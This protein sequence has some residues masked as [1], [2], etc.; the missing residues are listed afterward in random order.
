MEK[1]KIFSHLRRPLAILLAFIMVFSV[2]RLDG[3]PTAYAESTG[4]TNSA[5]TGKATNVYSREADPNTMDT[6]QDLLLNETNGSRYAGRIWTDKTVFA[7]GTDAANGGVTDNQIALDMATDGYEGSVGFSAD[8]AHVFSALASSQVVNEYPPQPLDVMFLLDVSGSMGATGLD[9][10]GNTTYADESTFENS[11]I[12]KTVNAINGAI[13]ILVEKNP[14]SRFGIA[15]YGSTA[16]VLV[17]LDHYTKGELKAEYDNWY[18]SSASNLQGVH[19][20]LTATVT[21]K[22]SGSET[23]YYADNAGQTS[24]Q[25]HGKTNISGNRTFFGTGGHTTGTGTSSADP[26][27]VGHITN[28]QAGLAAAMDQFIEHPELTWDTQITGETYVRL[29]ALIHLTDGQ[30]SDLSWI[31]S[32]ESREHDWEKTGSNWNNVDWR[33]DLAYNSPIN[34]QPSSSN[35]YYNASQLTGHGDAAPVIFQTLMTASYYKSAVE[36][37]Y[38]NNESGA[39]D[40]DG[41]P[42]S[43]SCYSIYASDTSGYNTL[44]T[45]PQVKATVDAILGPEEHF[46][47]ADP[48]SS[49][50][51]SS[52]LE[53]VSDA[54]SGQYIDTAYELFRKWKD[55]SETVTDTFTKDTT[56]NNKDLNDITITLNTGID[57]QDGGAYSAETW[58]GEIT[59]EVVAKNINYVPTDNFYQTGFAELDNLF[60][61]IIQLLLG[62]VFIPI[63][64]DNDAGV[65]DSITYQDPIGDLMEVKNR[66]ITATP[67]HTGEKLGL[68]ETTYDMAMLLFGEM[69]GMVRTGVYDY[70]WHS[71]YLEKNPKSTHSNFLTSGWYYGDAVSAVYGGAG[72]VPKVSEGSVPEGKN[73]TYDENDAGAAKAWTD[74]WV[75][76][77]DY[78][79]LT[80]FIP[81]TEEVSDPSQLSPQ[82]QN[83]V[84]TVYRFNCDNEDRNQLRRN[85]VYGAVPEDLKETWKQ[86]YI[87]NHNTYPA[88][89]TM[90]EDVPGVFRLSDIRVWVEEYGDYVD[91]GNLTPSQSY[92]SSLYVNIPVAAVPTQ[93]AE[94]SINPNGDMS[95]KTNLDT[96][97]QS[98][99][100]R[101]FYAVGLD[102]EILTEDGSSVNITAIPSEYLEEHRDE[103]SRIE[104]I[105]N[106]YSDTVYEDYATSAANVTRGD[107]TVSFSPSAD[108]RYYVFQKPLPL[109]AHAYRVQEDGSLALVDNAT[110]TWDDKTSGGNGKS[111]WESYNGVQQS[112]ASW[113]GGECLGTF[114]SKEKF[115]EKYPS[116][117]GQEGKIVF[118][119][120]DLMDHVTSDA[121]GNY[122]SGSLS[123]S[124]DDYFFMLVE[125]Y[126]PEKGTIGKDK[127]GNEAIGTQKCHVVQY[128]VARKGSEFGSGLEAENISNGDMLCWTDTSGKIDQEIRYNSRSDT[129]DNTR[130]EPTYEKL[131]GD[132]SKLQD[133]LKSCGVNT[134]NL[135]EEAQYW[136]ALREEPSIKAALKKAAE[137][138]HHAN[139]SELKKEE[140]EKSFHWAVVAKEGGLRVGD[141]YQNVRRKTENVTGTSSTYY[142]PTLSP[143][144]GI[145]NN[146]VI[147]NYLGNNGKLLVSDMLL[148]VTKTVKP[149][150]LGSVDPDESFS[151]QV[152]LQG[153][154]GKTANAVMVKKDPYTGLWRR[155][156]ASIDVLTN[157]QG[158]LLSSN[159]KGLAVVDENINPIEN[160]QSGEPSYYV[161]I[162]NS[163]AVKDNSVTVYSAPE[164][165]SE[166][167]GGYTEYVSGEQLEN[168]ENTDHIEYKD[169]D[170]TEYREGDIVFWTDIAISLIPVS[171]V[172]SNWDG[173]TMPKDTIQ[174]TD[175]KFPITTLKNDQDQGLRS[176]MFM[177]SIFSVRSTYLTTPVEFGLAGG[178]SALYDQTAFQNPRKTESFES[179]KYEGEELASNTAQFTLKDGEGLLFTGMDYLASFRV[180]EKLSDEQIKKHYVLDGVKLIQNTNYVDFSLADEKQPEVSNTTNW[181][182]TN[183]G[184]AHVDGYY[185]FTIGP[186]RRTIS[187]PELVEDVRPNNAAYFDK[188]GHYYSVYGDTSELEKAAHFTNTMQIPMPE[189]TETTPGDGELVG[190]G[191]SITYEIH[192]ENYFNNKN[193][194]EHIIV[195]DTLDPGVTY[196]EKNPAKAYKEPGGSEELT[197]D[198]NGNI[199]TAT[200]YDEEQVLDQNSAPPLSSL[201]SMGI[202]KIPARTV[203]WDLG[204]QEPGATGVVRLNVIVN[205]NAKVGY[206]YNDTADGFVGPQGDSDYEVFNQ[207][208]VKVGNNPFLLTEIVDNPVPDK[209]E[210]AIDRAGGSG[211]NTTS[212]TVTEGDNLKYNEDTKLWEGPL[213]N[214]GDKITYEVTWKNN[215]TDHSLI[216]VRDPLDPGVDFVSASYGEITLKLG[217]GKSN[218]ASGTVSLTGHDENGDPL[219]RTEIPVTIQYVAEG[220][221]G[222]PEIVWTIGDKNAA[223]GV[224][225]K[226]VPPGAGGTVGLVVE[227]TDRAT[228][229]GQVENTAFVRVGNDSVER[230]TKTVENPTPKRSK[231][232]T[233]PGNGKLVGVGSE[234]TYEINWK[235]YSD[236]VARIVVMDKLDPGVDFGNASVY[237]KG[238]GG[239]I[240]IEEKTEDGENI[241]I[242]YYKEAGAY[243]YVSADGETQEDIPV[244]AHTV[245]WDLGVRKPREEGYVGL[246]VKVNKNARF[247][248]NYNSDSTDFVEGAKDAAGNLGNDYEVFN[249][250]R[251]KVDNDEFLKTELVENPVSDKTEEKPGE[252]KTVGVGT[253]ITYKVHWE[254]PQNESAVVTITDPLDKGVDFVSA[255][256]DGV[257][258]SAVPDGGDV[259]ITGEGAVFAADDGTG[260][261]KVTIKYD[262]ENHTV[263]WTF[264]ATA[265]ANTEPDV[266]GVFAGD[267]SLEVCVNQEAY[268]KW[269]YGTGRGVDSPVVDDDA[270]DDE[271][272]NRAS[273]EVD[274]EP[275]VYTDVIH[276]PLETGSLTV[277]KVVTPVEV[278]GE[279]DNDAEFEFQVDLQAQNGDGLRGTLTYTIYASNGTQKGDPQ[280]YDAGTTVSFTLKNGEYAVF[281][282][283]PIVTK[284]VVSEKWKEDYY[285]KSTE[286]DGNDTPFTNNA[287]AESY[288]V[289]GTV[290]VTDSTGKVSEVKEV[291]VQYT[292]ER[293]HENEKTETVPGPDLQ[294]KVGDQITYQIEWT[295]DQQP[296]ATVK[297]TDY[298]DKGVDFVSASDNGQYDAA[299]HVV[300]WD[301][302]SREY[303]A[304][305][306][307]TLTVRVNKDAVKNW[308]YGSGDD[309]V[310]D[311]TSKD[312]EVR[313]RAKIEINNRSEYTD[314]VENPVPEK[315]ES[316]PGDGEIVG[317]GDEITYQIGWANT[318]DQP[319]T[320]VI[321]DPLDPG[322]DFVSASFGG[323]ISDITLNADTPGGHVDSGDGDSAAETPPT[324]E[325]SYDPGTH[326]VTWT[327]RNVEANDKGT[328][329]LTVRVNENAVK[330]WSYGTGDDPVVD[331]NKD[332]EV[333]NRAQVKV[334]DDSVY[335]EIV[336]NPI[337]E[338]TESDPGDG[339]LVGVGDEITYKVHWEN[340]HDQKATVTITDPLDRGVDFVSASL[341]NV[342]LTAAAD[343]GSVHVDGVSVGN[344][345]ENGFVEADGNGQKN[346]SITYDKNSHTVTW[347]FT[348]SAL[349]NTEPDGSGVFVG[350][351]ELKVK[352]NE[353]A[354]ETW[355]YHDSDNK[356][357]PEG[358][359][360]TGKDYEVVN[361]AL[362]Q[363]G[364]DAAYTNEVENPIPEK[365]ESTPGDGSLVGVGDEIA[366]K[367]H[368]ENLHEEKTVVTITD[369]LDQGVDFVS[370]SLGEVTLPAAA[371]GGST[372][373]EG[374]AAIASIEGDVTILYDK[375]SHA[376][377]WIFTADALANTKPDSDGTFAAD[378]ELKVKVNENAARTWTYG[379]TADK[380]QPG[381]NYGEGEDYEVVNRAL[382]Q[383]GDNAAYTDEV[384]NPVPGK[385]EEKPGDGEVVGVGDEITYKVHWENTNDEEADVTITDPLDDGVDFLSASLGSV[386]LTAGHA[387][388][389][390]TGA[391]GGSEPVIGDVTITYAGHVVTWT[392]RAEPH[393]SGDVTLEVKVNERAAKDWKYNE[394]TDSGQSGTGRDFKVLN[395][396]GVKVN[397][398]SVYTAVVENPVPEK[399]EVDPGD[400]FMVGLG[401]KITYKVHWENLHDQKAVVTI[402]D[403]LDKGVDFVSASFDGVTLT[404]AAD[405]GSTRIDSTGIG[406]GAEDALVEAD[407]NGQR[408]ISIAYDKESHTVT[409]TF[410]AR[411]LANTV[412]DGDAY[413]GDVELIV[414][415]NENAFAAWNYGSTADKTRPEGKDGFGKDY[416]VRNRALVQVGN[417]AAYT[418]EV[419][420]PVPEKRE[421]TPGSGKLVEV[422]D[423][424]N[425]EIHWTN[426]HDEAATVVVTDELDQGVDFVS[427]SYNGVVLSKD[428]N[429]ENKKTVGDFTIEYD[430]NE[431]TVT[432]TL[433][434]RAGHASGYVALVVSVNENAKPEG[435]VENQAGVKVGNDSEVK[436]RIIP[437]PTG[438]AKTE[439]KVNDEDVSGDLVPVEDGSQGPKVKV[440]D[441]VTYRITWVNS[442]EENGELVPATVTVRDPLDEGVDFESAI[443][444][445]KNGVKLE[446]GA[447]EP[448]ADKDGILRKEQGSAAIAYDK[449]THTVTWTLRD[450][451]PGETGTVELTVRVNQNAYYEWKYGEGD[452]S[453]S[454]DD[455]D[456][457]IVDRA[458]VQAGNGPEIYTE[459]IHNPLGTGRLRIKKVVAEEVVAPAE[460]NDETD[461][462]PEFTFQ[463]EL[464]DGS[465]QPLRG[466][467]TYTVY[468]SDGTVKKGPVTFDADKSVE[469][470][471]AQ[472]EYVLFD[473]LP[474]VTK[475]TVSEKWTDDYHLDSAT[476]DGKSAEVKY[477]A[478]GRRY[479]VSGSVEAEA[480]VAVEY[481]NKKLDLNQKTEIDPEEDR[482]VVVGDQITYQINWSNDQHAAANVKVTDY[483]DKGVDF[484]SADNNGQYDADAHTVT[485]DLGERP[486]GAHGTVTLTVAVNGNAVK[487]WSYGTGDVPVED[488]GSKDYEVRNR[489]KIEVGNHSEYTNV[490]EN[491]VPEKEE[492]TPGDGELVG[493]GD[494]IDYQIGWANTKN[495]KAKVVITDPLDQGVDFV[496]ASLGDTTLTAD[497]AGGSVSISDGDLT[498]GKI[499]TFTI[500]YDAENHVVTWTLLNTEAN[501]K[502]TVELTVRV[503]ENAVRT[504]TYDDEE[505]QGA[506]GD[507]KDYEIVNRAQ[508]SVDN[509]AVYTETVENPVPEKEEVT[510]GDGVLVG[511]GD[512]ISYKVHWENIH[513]R[514]AVVTITDPLDKGVDFVSASLGSVTLNAAADGGSVRID[515]VGIGS[516]TEDAFVE[517]DGNGQRKISI[518]YDKDSHTVTWTFTAR[519]LA[520]TEPDG[521]GIFPGDA[522]LT[523]KVNENAARTW[524]Y[525]DITDKN[526]PGGD[527]G[528]GVDYEVVNRALVKV[529]DHAAFTEEVENPVPEKTENTPGEGKAVGVGE[530]ITYGIHWINDHDEK[531]KV[532]VTDPLD[533]GVD[534]AEASYGQDGNGVKLTVQKDTQGKAVDGSADGAFQYDDG[535]TAN[536]TITY[537][538]VSHTVTWVIDAAPV[539]AEGDVSLKVVVNEK[540]KPVG[541]V[542][543]QAGVQVGNDAQVET[544]IIPNPTPGKTETDPGE[545]RQVKVGDRI[546]YQIT[547]SNQSGDDAAVKVTDRLDKGVIFVSADNNGQYDAA[548][549]T[550]TWD[551]GTQPDGAHGTVTLTVEVNENAVKSWS[552]GTGDEIAEDDS[553]KDYEVRN[554]AKIEVGNHSEYTNE[555]ENP[556]PEKEEV[557]PGDGIL[558]GVDETIDY[559]IGWANTKDQPAVVVITDPLDEGVDF[560]SASYDGV[561]LTAADVTVANEGG[562]K[563]SEDGDEAA[564]KLPTVTVSYSTK[565]HTVTWTLRNVEANAR[566]TVELTVKVNENAV[567]T[568]TY[569][570]EAN[571]GAYSEGKDHEVV[572]RAQVSVDNDSVYTEIVENPVPEKEENTPGAGE[573]V[574]AGDGISYDI[575]WTNGHDEKAKVTVTDP[576]DQGVDFAEASYGQGENRVEL[577]V[578]KDA[579]GTIIDN[580]VTGTFRYDE[581]TTANVT[582]TYS[583]ASHTVTWVI[584][585]APAKAEGDVSLEVVVNEK[586]K[587]AGGVKNKAGVQ[588]GND[589][590]VE[591][592]I[593]PNPI[594]GKTETDPGEDRQVKV[595]DRIT[596]QITWSNQSEADAAV[597]VTDRLDKGVTFVSADNNGQYDAASHT[598][599]WELGTQ[600]K[601]ARGTVTLT[602]EVNENAVK[603]WSY[604][605]ASGLTPDTPIENDGTKD[606][607]VRN[608]ARIEV[609]N[610]SE[611]T[612]EVENPVPE[613]EEVTP[614]DGILVGVG[615][616]IDYQIGWANTKD[617]TA[618]VVITDPLDEGVDFVSASFGKVELTAA[619]VTVDGEGGS[620]DSGDGTAGKLPT[621]TVSYS[622]KD[623]TVTWTLRNVE[624]NA[625]GTV[626][627]KV[628][629]NENAV[630]T[631]TYADEAN[632]G[633]YGEGKDHEVVNRAQVSV[634]ND[635][636]YT[637]T[638]ENPVPEKE[639]T[640]PGANE[641]V[642]VGRK[643]A[644]AIHWTN[645]H[646]EDAKVTVTDPLDQGVDFAEASYGQDGNGV[647]LSV[648][649]DAQGKAVD[650]SATGTFRYSDG[651]TANVTITY[652]AANHTVTWI[653][654]EAPAKAEGDVSLE[655]VVNEKARP[656][657]GVKNQAG[658]QVGNDA[659]VKTRIIPNPT[660]PS[661]TETQVNDQD[662]SGRLTP[663]EDGYQGPRVKV[664]DA[665]DYQIAWVNSAEEDGTP[666][667]AN[668]IVRDPLDKGVDFTSASFTEEDGVTL[669]LTAGEPDADGDGILRKEQGSV[670]IEYNKG[671]HTV[672]WTLKNREAGAAGTVE[673]KVEVNEN[674]YRTWQYGVEPRP[675]EPEID[676]TR[677]DNEVVNRAKV[678]VVDV[679]NR[680]YTEQ[681]TDV[682]HNPLAEPAIVNLELTKVL[683]DE[684]EGGYTLREGMF[685][686]LVTP[687][688]N[689]SEGDPIGEAFTVKNGASSDGKTAKAAIFDNVRYGQA[690]VYRYTVREVIPA[691]GMPDMEFDT[692]T[693]TVTVTV[694]ETE[695]AVLTAKTTV[696]D[697]QGVWV[698][699]DGIRFT[700]TFATDTGVELQAHKSLEGGTLE[701]DEFTFEL[702]GI[703]AVYE[704]VSGGD[705]A[706][707][708][709]SGSVSDSD[710]SGNDVSDSDV[711]GGN[712]SGGDVSG[713][714]AAGD[715]S[716]NKESDANRSAAGGALAGS[717]FGLRREE[718][719]YREILTKDGMPPM[720][721][722]GTTRT[723]GTGGLVSFGSVTYTRPGVYTYEIS[724]RNDGR[725]G[726]I[727]DETVYTVT[728]VVTRGDDGLLKASVKYNGGGTAEFVNKLEKPEEPGVG[729]LTVSKTVGGTAGETDKEFHFRVEL[730]DRGISGQYGGM[731]FAEGVAEFTLKHGESRTAD[732]LPAGVSYTVTE[733]EANE[734]GYDTTFNG[735]VGEIP[736]D[737]TAVASFLN[738]KEKTPP[739]PRTGSLTVTKTV[740]G[741]T[742]E[743]DREFHFRVELEAKGVN[744]QYGDLFF[745]QGVAE[746]TLKHGESLTARDLPAD[747][748]YTVTETEANLDGYVTTITG[749]QGMITDGG[750]S[751]A[752]FVNE[753]GGTEE[754]VPVPSE[755]Q[756]PPAAA[757]KTGDSG[758]LGTWFALL[759]ASLVC[760]A[761][762]SRRLTGRR[763]RGNG[764]RIR[765]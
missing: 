58:A 196:D 565:N 664:G 686:F 346:I 281:D 480:E 726:V 125:Y 163:D 93:L 400:G 120:E 219:T 349:A 253:N 52:T 135:E 527:Y 350:D 678:S 593:I 74:G 64:G 173:T 725:P 716:G 532:T 657:G 240:I 215:E 746:F 640:A 285:L 522:G 308:S 233:E 321:T 566:G 139:A 719:P 652:S 45:K 390:R 115:Y 486:D 247:V 217:E 647:K 368:W 373:I 760:V 704:E 53:T 205:K 734:D 389:T 618:T 113:V 639:E 348:A 517:A 155:R 21:E 118:L 466:T 283:L 442:A 338:K 539:K 306:V 422:G 564:G 418:D 213:V 538:A 706:G 230:Q 280:S 670:I 201:F 32:G 494:T 304:N 284:Y 376:V 605:D 195:M 712:V 275:K 277:R 339:D 123:F 571:Q 653:I 600:P 220:E 258:L 751:M 703:S 342:T 228:P 576:L 333:Q 323:G 474:I 271:V 54:T 313:N 207:A 630:R 39:R 438:P 496:S 747:F 370:A 356:D 674:A 623:H 8:F 405:G 759:A 279:V 141:M 733:A 721:A 232:E 255:S 320:V 467:L 150:E 473:N 296:S 386:F 635:A 314:I 698:G 426:G 344:G 318:K 582:I 443:F 343:G 592:Q 354:I 57:P 633:A 579:Q 444:T 357:H 278:G 504:W 744:G 428:E 764:K 130:G 13:D 335:T 749:D 261:K 505:N 359:P 256:F 451:K 345:P 536:V 66:S 611:Y 65:G 459:T 325:I 498:V 479:S 476:I 450:R 307:V 482:P 692:G 254:N 117:E 462:D 157:N 242:V 11:A 547:W 243:H 619:D 750:H 264:T 559:Q 89:N 165:D 666:V 204:I 595:G 365:T 208:R 26:I 722:G 756:Q 645:G 187:K 529:G 590:Q 121:E 748:T 167:H 192:W 249:Q 12:Y 358:Y 47:D 59:H 44:T 61:Q 643:I 521:S 41:K 183:P 537:S 199:I 432:W 587:P 580:T 629:V 124:S 745:E 628:K 151:F 184:Y 673:L 567:K 272:V 457:Q 697:E 500:S 81:L 416:E 574:E 100:L 531:A 609:G 651:T 193:D 491:P 315:T 472:D 103:M 71:E 340:P 361:R 31:T 397:D 470:Q 76:R 85:P 632:Q 644:Y 455:R 507:G 185:S 610:R 403:P 401:D 38:N 497:A 463:V 14:E 28:A 3:M 211:G 406:N 329:K 417:N 1:G 88:N 740:T 137:V 597:K 702:K 299:K 132:A 68:G 128:A 67:Y 475:Y 101:L 449:N 105:S 259:E 461:T 431:H 506:Y 624:A 622:T 448:D 377:T 727:Y 42:V 46:T 665:I 638:V 583:A 402:T 409:W 303:G 588:V 606:Y 282:K 495:Q 305:G 552:Y 23:I 328:V 49:K 316:D 274:N 301:L 642:Q 330:S 371:D 143:N 650:G 503:N 198:A 50:T 672:T 216:T 743:T 683:V 430:A 434:G 436:T 287:A 69:H 519:A 558:V 190:V 412:P 367:V 419:E 382:V 246:T 720:P 91:Q 158:L 266:S 691:S 332:Y 245:V 615:E 60:E 427:A 300:V 543:N 433:A 324:L 291:T 656:A 533:Q 456:D 87:D 331:N 98:T 203:V 236:S 488:D 17:P 269:Q 669:T 372:G 72:T 675:E 423:T 671:T 138:Y 79:T 327:L 119:E 180:T 355:K 599:T 437:N 477:D 541:G 591:T 43:L 154:A 765:R 317:I 225:E 732:N 557:T 164:I 625:R 741:S 352:V 616:T 20:K 525:G 545:D 244:P 114:E 753:R 212:E 596:Y 40:K 612:N 415:V 758:S 658:V 172:P 156:I 694:V 131:V 234:I 177:D 102:D 194:K 604:G 94:I 385:T 10:S 311:D 24:D 5:T 129:G 626:E 471:L 752:A 379:D 662:V 6:Y 374:D 420:N 682:L 182:T 191:D 660:G 319:A 309:P 70:Y 290:P 714:N 159:G 395:R 7:Y 544:R 718:T 134:E 484:V 337:P 289:S 453:I 709:E 584:D 485:W 111:T 2:V 478:D 106:Y 294:V 735:N 238:A 35:T 257:K 737:G 200:Y 499:P 104:F 569:D 731:S 34:N 687:A 90:Y 334:D 110:D 729:K 570:D 739:K 509:D 336:E 297:V 654:D 489:A 388:G 393:S 267:V 86:Y 528:E 710:V 763:A 322:V 206:D 73:W 655:V 684:N 202:T 761:A 298:L 248:Y 641:T 508:V 425:Y 468:N 563:D 109:Y 189:K 646:D 492:V 77:L 668:V 152:F 677:N 366:Y 136:L 520:N 171:N 515:S 78:K 341:G 353:S 224:T 661:K 707:G 186:D 404:A 33:Y 738:Y 229:A 551:L 603:S 127:E 429:A 394:T 723:N 555:V 214:V 169:V 572:N 153:M 27:H 613:K 15:I 178:I 556:V 222:T 112:A 435:G 252:N 696:T 454:S 681:Y 667:R 523:V 265:Q 581:E 601:G 452:T 392:F 381:G 607:E 92:D 510:P 95:Y 398:K 549:H 363:V 166:H 251:V 561:E 147:N 380:T 594:P 762:A 636:V 511:L 481:T 270:R 534:F 713:S 56:S 546:T 48:N 140:Y 648:Q 174:K 99:P 268:Y 391:P 9:G 757:P 490:V 126:M 424:I 690:G 754:S 161:W 55:G 22:G 689:N 518:A 411:A 602:V 273:V 445:E 501:S 711:S 705:A 231:T 37:L 122:V 676:D 383:V 146:I 29:P 659:E 133:Y 728:V 627:L 524:E 351:V 679:N 369:P 540:A 347:T 4:G 175:F 96:K 375:D 589:A 458:S 260:Q 25:A 241:S 487:S 447:T 227:V 514:K 209:T 608:R 724:E 554:R 730:G 530:E 620:K 446:L 708:T 464:K 568:W 575:H 755:P 440:G 439:T 364:N 210:T 221:D 700:N 148:L 286:I 685:T 144:S 699:I 598:V 360:G 542:K 396:A 160:P 701:E 235:N 149:S 145:G 170:G 168:T 176:G 649:K 408:K 637:D 410:T 441:T 237:K 617:Q 560:V 293:L 715:N 550:V 80:Q 586:A 51:D 197:N 142:V 107:P 414:S 421:I 493:V 516:G 502:G 553:T 399:E 465:G 30:A 326:T 526:E 250:A 387:G 717:L 84:Y 512:E 310:V 97:E 295:N 680:P 188:D 162:N 276:N 460:G 18:G 16:A 226:L 181:G 535:T 621:I 302:G 179:K 288:Q 239:Q 614:G 407:G 36:A 483:L 63:S 578:R 263:T 384:E 742:G 573:V 312:Y 548:S 83:T 378:V 688:E 693:Y 413:A 62:Q 695:E 362:V 736:E 19:F 75:Y 223:E 108:N 513:E 577:T 292:N 634:D 218:S 631:W 469:V 262:K 663:V 82:I 562:S 116:G 585:E